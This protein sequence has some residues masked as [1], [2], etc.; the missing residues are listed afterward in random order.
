MR[1]GRFILFFL[2]GAAAFI[3]LVKVPIL[4]KYFTDKLR[5]RVSIEWVSIWPS[6]T[7]IRDLK[8]YNPQGFTSPLA[9]EINQVHLGYRLKEL[10]VNPL[11]IEQIECDSLV[12]NIEFLKPESAFNNW[13]LIHDLMQKPPTSESV[14]IRRLILTDINIVIQGRDASEQTITHHVDRLE[15]GNIQS[16]RGLLVKDLIHKVFEGAHLEQYIADAF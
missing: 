11:I 2:I 1:F 12:L 16:E 6:E 8:I 9:L 3:W 15:W 10:I 13:M 7:T 5:Q 4:S 14:L